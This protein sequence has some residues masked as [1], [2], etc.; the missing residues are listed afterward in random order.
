[1]LNSDAVDVHEVLPLAGELPRGPDH[2]V[3]NH[4]SFS[5]LRDLGVRNQ[6]SRNQLIDLWL[7]K[8]KNEEI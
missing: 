2:H 7:R 3:R 4:Q 8:M 1:M 5:W 6:K